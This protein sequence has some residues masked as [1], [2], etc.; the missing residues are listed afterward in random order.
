MKLRNVLLIVSCFLLHAARGDD[1]EF[2]TLKVV[3]PFARATP[4]GAK[5]GG[6]YMS[7]ENTGDKPDTLVGVSST[8]A[9]DVAVHQMQM[10][11]GVMKMSA[12]PAIQI[13]PHATLALGP[14]GYHVMLSDLRAPLKVGERFPLQLRFEKAGKIDVSVTVEPM[15]AATPARTDR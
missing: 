9:A 6:V 10:E 1:F 3:H 15:G 8:V 7:I 4:P 13:K 11:G 14:G 2:G 12:A 5:S